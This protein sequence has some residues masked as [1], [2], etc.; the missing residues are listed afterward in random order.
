MSSFF[1]NPSIQPSRICDLP[2]HQKPREKLIEQGP[3]SLSDAEL[4]ALFIGTGSR[5]QSAIELGQSLIQRHGSLSAIGGIDA[6]ELAKEHGFGLAKATRLVAAF[7]LGIR[8]SR[9]GI[10]AETLDAPEVID[11]YFRPQLQHLPQEKVMVAA[12]DC[13]LRHLSSHTIS[14]G[15][16]NESIAH[17]RDILRPVMARGAHGFILIHN[18]PSGDPSPSR[19]DH[20]VTRRVQAAAELMQLRFVDHLIIGRA[21]NGSRPWFSFRESGKIIE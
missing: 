19:A 17:P 2:L 14:I 21:S 6:S 20:E 7:E 4:I 15:S 10:H 18:H 9:E 13:R 11:R 5:G 1:E 8:V 12:V 16:V 3:A